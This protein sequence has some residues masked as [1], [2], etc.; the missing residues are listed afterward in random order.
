MNAIKFY[1]TTGTYKTVLLA[2]SPNEAAQSAISRFIT[3]WSG[4]TES[5]SVDTFGKET[6]VSEVGF[7]MEDDD[8]SPDHKLD[9]IYET[10]T[11]LAIERKW[12]LEQLEKIEK[13]IL[14][15]KRKN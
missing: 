7:R 6:K 13:K 3:R 11:L 15:K 5:F 1:I 8:S 4:D 10:V 12:R 2:N 9:K 14:R